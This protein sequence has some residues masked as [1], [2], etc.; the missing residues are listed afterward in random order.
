MEYHAHYA[1]AFQNAPAHN[2]NFYKTKNKKEK[3]ISL[4][5]NISGLMLRLSLFHA[6]V[7]ARSNYRSLGFSQVRNSPV[8]IEFSS[9]GPYEFGHSDY[10]AARAVAFDELKEN[11]TEP[12]LRS[13]SHLLATKVSRR[14]LNHPAM[15]SLTPR[16]GGTPR[17]PQVGFTNSMDP[18]G[19]EGMV[20]TTRLQFMLGE[21]AYG[22]RIHDTQSRQLSPGKKRIGIGEKLGKT[23]SRVSRAISRIVDAFEQSKRN[24]I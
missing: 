12:K 16:G 19:D 9:G 14:Q 13:K 6:L 23:K 4:S 8:G 17:A 5:V 10:L 11:L 15:I 2:L 22:S 7:T 20:Y 3:G 21:V 1:R 18:G 24:R